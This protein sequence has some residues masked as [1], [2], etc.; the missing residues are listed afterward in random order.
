M[1]REGRPVV[2][3]TGGTG[4]IGG[5]IC[6]RFSE[7]YSVVALDVAAPQQNKSGVEWRQCDLTSDA[8]VKSALASVRD[9]YGG[10]L[11]S[12]IHL[13]AYYDFAGEPSP[14][15]SELTVEGTRRLVKRLSDFEQVEQL[16][17]SSSLLV[18]QP[19]EPGQ[20][21]NE[22]SPTQAEWEYPQS[23]LEAERVLR[24]EHGPIPTV[25]LRI[26]GVYDESGHSIP[27]TQNIRR[28]AEK[29]FES[30]FFPGDSDRGQ[31]FVHLD[32][33]VEAF[34]LVVENRH[35]LS[36]YEVFLIAEEECLTYE[37]LQD[38]IGELVHGISDWPT[39]RIPKALAKTGAWVKEQLASSEEE[40]PFIRP[41]MVDI[42]D[43]HYAVDNLR[44]KT[45]LGWH[46]RH[47]LSETLPDMVRRL[48]RNPR[49][50]YET[51]GLPLP[52]DPQVLESL[53]AAETTSAT[54]GK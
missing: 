44:A 3:V 9:K 29:E 27:I 39:V 30:Y 10:H 38:Q 46:P 16:V 35:Q 17:F 54:G 25:V 45:V 18:M 7:N 24:R 37:Q 15:Y 22:T 33:V 12:V 36:P 40:K 4:L 26:A 28:I 48:K 2:L 51:N 14:L 1:C 50:W 19:C 47:R 34:S 32:D 31:A 42:A 6:D 20:S 53:A 13:A 41:W 21:I 11:A 8:S 23:K 43:A 49:A 5:R 52:D